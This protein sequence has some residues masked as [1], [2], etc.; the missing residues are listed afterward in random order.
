MVRQRLTACLLVLTGSGRCPSAAH[1][2]RP[3]CVVG[4]AGTRQARS[5]DGYP[6]DRIPVGTDLWPVSAGHYTPRERARAVLALTPPRGGAGSDAARGNAMGVWSAGREGDRGRHGLIQEPRQVSP[7]GVGCNGASTP[8][9]GGQSQPAC[10]A[11]Q[12]GAA[13]VGCRSASY[14]CRGKS[15][16]RSRIRRSRVPFGDGRH[17]RLVTQST[18]RDERGCQLTPVSPCSLRHTPVHAPMPAVVT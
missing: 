11:T 6:S 2:R 18:A 13:G 15:A 7:S 10:I 14:S 4:R 17:R 5:L 12:S 8:P 9:S 1:R 16:L 3:D